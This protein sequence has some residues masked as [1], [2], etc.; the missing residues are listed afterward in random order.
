MSYLLGGPWAEEQPSSERMNAKSLFVGTG[1]ELADVTISSTI[2]LALVT[3]DGSGFLANHIY[4]RHF[5]PD[6]GGWSGWDDVFKK[7]THADDTETE[8]G[9]YYD[10][11]V[12]NAET[13]LSIF[14]PSL[15]DEMFYFDSSIGGSIAGEE[16]A[17][18]SLAVQTIHTTGEDATQF[19]RLKTGTTTD[20]WAQVQD[21]G[22]K[23]SVSSPLQWHIKFQIVGAATNILW[24]M[25]VGMER[26]QEESEDELQ[27]I[28][29]EGCDGDGVTTQLVTCDGATRLKT[30]TGVAMILDPEG[31]IGAKIEYIPST[32]VIYYDTLGTIKE[33]T[34]N[35]PSDGA[36]KSDRM[37][38]YGIKTTN[39]TEKLMYLWADAL[40]GKILDPA[41]I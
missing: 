7:H 17:A 40:Y 35:I 27:K 39:T 11:D 5:D 28:G 19:L 13:R 32:S 16:N 21:G 34:G 6:V 8:G 25:G 4:T 38:R 36:L 9:D 3:E 41:W 23:I 29:L 2:A 10:I 30:S 24:R 15:Q 26:V 37:L 18:S 22:L 1:D 33:S 12:A 14:R 31:A 20:N